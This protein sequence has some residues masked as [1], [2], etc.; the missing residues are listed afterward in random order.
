MITPWRRIALSVALV[1]GVLDIAL[2]G[3]YGSTHL[4]LV[5]VLFVPA[6]LLGFAG[7]ST[8]FTNRCLRLDCVGRRA[9]SDPSLIKLVLAVIGA[10]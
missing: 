7:G 2:I 6:R 10:G 4:A 8:I 3:V 1:L 5:V 9:P